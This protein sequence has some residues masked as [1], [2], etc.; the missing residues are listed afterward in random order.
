M[1]PTLVLFAALLGGWSAVAVAQSPVFSGAITVTATTAAEPLVAVP[2]AADVVEADTIVERKAEQVVDLLR[3]LPGLELAQSGARGKATSLFTRGTNSN[4]T[5]V[6]WNGV[7]LN[8]PYLGGFDWST[9]AT[10]GV[11]RL[12]VVRGPYSALYGS[13]ALGGVVQLVSRRGGQGGHLR[14]EGGEGDFGR[15]GASV[16][17]ARGVLALDVAGHLRRGEGVVANDFYDGGEVDLSLGASW[18]EAGR[19]G[20]V[21]RHGGSTVG[22][23]YDY[24]GLPSPERRQHLAT[25][26]V[27]APLSYTQER[28]T[29]EG[30]AS[31][32][33]SALDLH[34][35]LDPFAASDTT[36][37]RDQARALVRRRLGDELTLV[38][39]GEWER[40]RASSSTAF[41]AGLTDDRAELWAAFGQLS[42]THEAWRVDAGVR[43]DA[44]DRFGGATSLRG[45]VAWRPVEHL[46]LR[47]A[48]GEGFRAP[49]LADLYYPGFGNPDLQP[50]RS[51]SWEA[52]LDAEVGVVRLSATAFA[53]DLDHLIEFDYATFLPRNVGAARIRGAEASVVARRGI[54]EGRLAATWLDAENRAT[55]GALLRRPEWSGSGAVTLRHRAWTAAAIARY[56][57]ERVDFGEVPLARYATV[58]LTLARRIAE[59]WEPFVRIENAA[60]ARYEE[61]AGYPAPGRRFSAGLDWSF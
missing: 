9:L 18:N 55:G 54:V 16:G 22:I 30:Q 3:T 43:R 32:S 47:A 23:P 6:L 10:D 49:S 48:Y 7:P 40:Q 24:S 15:V 39:G 58:D 20:L 19:I 61:V 45:A 21:V 38:G 34:D 41:G 1:R 8:D 51:R 26:T 27:A 57:G 17:R 35:P 5:L 4:H 33:A 50:E 28:W 46:R 14:L 11:E 25:T 2:T 53:T 42:Y 52:G 59:R 44:H 29:I 60:D 13:S 56:V 36:A 31:T 12:E 37:H